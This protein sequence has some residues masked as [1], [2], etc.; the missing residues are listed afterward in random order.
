MQENESAEEDVTPLPRSSR[1]RRQANNLNQSNEGAFDDDDSD[2]EVLLSQL[3]NNQG[4]PKRNFRMFEN[5]I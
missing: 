2:D 5:T 1:L 3:A 4:R